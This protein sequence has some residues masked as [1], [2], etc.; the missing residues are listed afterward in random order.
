LKPVTAQD[1]IIDVLRRAAFRPKRENGNVLSFRVGDANFIYETFGD[2]EGYARIVLFYKLDDS[3]DTE[4]LVLIANG[5][6]YK[7]RL[8]KTVIDPT[9]GGVSFAVEQLFR[10]I[11]TL[12]GQLSRAI[13]LLFASR[14]EFFQKANQF[15][16][17]S[18]R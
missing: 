12:E 3:V 18:Y 1:A 2:A 11:D 17:N 5:V 6:N 4:S 9:R 16:A 15:A 7:M 10:T 8:V 14:D 13:D